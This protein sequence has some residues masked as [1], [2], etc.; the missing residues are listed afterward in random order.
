MGGA[1]YWHQYLGILKEKSIQQSA[2][3]TSLG[4]IFTHCPSPTPVFM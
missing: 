2:P 1:H 3:L 4:D